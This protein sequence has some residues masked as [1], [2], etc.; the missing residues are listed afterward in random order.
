MERNK[1]V[2][3]CFDYSTNFVKPWAEAGYT[4]YCVDLQHEGGGSIQGN[5]IRVGADVREWLP[6]RMEPIAFAAFFPPCTDL[7]VSGASHFKR[8]GLGRLADAIDLFHHSVK[9]AEW[10]E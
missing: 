1:I 8:K 10:F 7:A 4:C 5:I 3:S 9:L 6:P 2:I